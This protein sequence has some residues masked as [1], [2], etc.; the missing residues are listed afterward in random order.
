MLDV[1]SNHWL[2]YVRYNSDHRE[3]SGKGKKLSAEE[4]VSFYTLN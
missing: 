1:I 4:Y 2:I 3:Y